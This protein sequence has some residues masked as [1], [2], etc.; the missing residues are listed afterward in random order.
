MH[1]NRP[2]S[3]VMASRRAMPGGGGKG[4]EESAADALMPGSPAAGLGVP[5][6]TE[7]AARL[8]GAPVSAATTW[9]EI[10]PVLPI[11]PAGAGAAVRCGAAGAGGACCAAVAP[12]T[13]S[14]TVIAA[15]AATHALTPGRCLTIAAS[16]LGLLLPESGDAERRG[17]ILLLINPRT[18]PLVTGAPA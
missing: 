11:S 2:V 13:P 14:M 15:S 7:T 10:R 12:R 16:G 4:V 1:S 5:P 17:Y 18:E 8:T 6:C 3:S 9:P